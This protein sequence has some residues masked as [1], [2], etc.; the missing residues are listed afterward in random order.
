MRDDCVGVLLAK[1]PVEP[2]RWAE[3]PQA[4]AELDES[5]CSVIWITDHLF[6][7]VDTPESL[8]MASVAAAATTCARVGVGV[9]QLPLRSPVAVA[10]AVA[11]LQ[12]VSGGRFVLGL[13]TG[14]HPAEYARCGASFERRGRALDEGIAALRELWREGP[15]RYVQLPNPPRVPLW[16]GGRSDAALR[17]TAAVGD[18]WLPIFLTPERFAEVNRRLDDALEAAS[19]SPDEVVRGAVV[20]VALTDGPRE[21][22]QALAWCSE[23]WDVAPERFERHLITGGPDDVARAVGEYRDA[24]AEHVTVMPADPDP[25][26]VVQRVLPA[27]RSTASPTL[28]GR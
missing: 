10:K 13:G 4:F 8:T 15:G 22:A 19:R 27:L 14:E 25:V 3:A 18:G 21:R 26:R 23:L 9:L 17:R 24:G 5:G 28:V 12:I 1:G 16:F 20:L 2:T 11:T 7:G 6:W